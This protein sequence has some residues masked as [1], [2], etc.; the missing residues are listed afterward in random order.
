MIIISLPSK[1]AAIE[2]LFETYFSLIADPRVL[3]AATYSPGR[4]NRRGRSGSY[5]EGASR[6]FDAEADCVAWFERVTNFSAY[7]CRSFAAG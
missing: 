4:N 6:F 5:G 2:V 1:R 7:P 3:D